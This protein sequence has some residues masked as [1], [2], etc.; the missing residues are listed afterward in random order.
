MAIKKF[1]DSIQIALGNMDLSTYKPINPFL[2]HPLFDKLWVERICKAIDKAEDNGVCRDKLAQ[3]IKGSSNLRSQLFFLLLDMKSARIEKE[4]RVKIANFFLEILKLNVKDDLPG[5]K[6]N[7]GHTPEMINIMLQKKFVKADPEI[8]RLL[9]R[10]YVVAYHLANGL[11]SDFYTDYGV[12]NF[13]PYKIGKD[14]ILVIKHFEDLKPELLWQDLDTSCKKITIY[15]IYKNVKFSCDAISAHSVYQGDPIT[16]L[17]RYFVEVDGKSMN[18][19]GDI[20]EL[21]EEIQVLAAS[22]WKH[23]V[24]LDEENLKLKVLSQRCYVLK[25]FFECLDIDWKPSQ[26][27]INAVKIKGLALEVWKPSEKDQKKYW[28][29][30]LDPASDFFG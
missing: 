26:E 1:I 18:S 8:A 9:G 13:G 30:I 6:S 20:Q 23:L 22:Q 27:L 7:I 29:Q 12:E 10:L 19:F 25:D 15:C 16:G 14:E 2:F 5:F 21:K 4:K 24:E 28:R 3:A 11:Y 17:V